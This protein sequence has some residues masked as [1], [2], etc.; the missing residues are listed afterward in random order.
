M[1]STSCFVSATWDPWPPS[2]RPRLATGRE[3]R[4]Q[5]VRRDHLE[6]RVAALARGLVRTPPPE[7]RGVAEAPALH[8]V[9][10][11]LDHQLRPERLPREILALAPAAVAPRHALRTRLRAVLA[12]PVPPGMIGERIRAVGRE[13]RD[14]L[15][16]LRVG[17]ARHHADVL[18]RARR[19][20]E[21]EQERADRHSGT[22]LVPAEARHHAVALPLVLHLEHHPLVRLVGAAFGL[23]HHAVQARALEAS[24]PVGRGAAL[25]GGRRQVQGRLG[26]LEQRLEL[27]AALAERA[28]A[29]V[30]IALAEKVPED[31][32]G[33][34]LLRQHRDA[35]GGGVD[36]QLQRL[37]VESA[38]PRDHDLAVEHAAPRELR[39]ERLAELREVAVERLLV[40][41]LQQELVAVAEDDH[42]ESVPL[43]LED[44]ARAV[45]QLADAPGEHRQHGRA[46]GELHARSLTQ[47]RSRELR[48]STSGPV[49]PSGRVSPLVFLLSPVRCTGQRCR[50]L[51][52]GRADSALALR[53]RR[54][55]APLGEVF[56]FV[57]ALYFRGKLGY[58][59]RF[60]QPPEG[61]PGVLVITPDRGLLAPETAIRTADLRA[62]A[63]VPIDAAEP[64]YARP[65][66]DHARDLAVRLPP[67][68]RIVLLGSIATPK[69]V[70]LLLAA[71]GRA[72]LFP[73]DFVGR[74]DMSR[75]GLLLR[76]E[77]AGVELGYRPVDGAVRRG[78]RAARLPVRARPP[79]ARRADGT[80][81]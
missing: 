72:L 9:V 6:L 69:Y 73:V 35:R 42:P 13:R 56:S 1:S 8:V 65:L 4:R 50:R 17:E 33:R 58:A 48:C 16:P 49:R 63:R 60:A 20:V 27:A 22:A 57:S 81:G 71:F 39:L 18:E 80:S 66:R 5:L 77:R 62:F 59:R 12:R 61:C 67:G 28:G 31:H 15:A 32:R 53:L 74:G 55:G 43:R 21:P 68:A 64:R 11:D 24:E 37:E 45:R 54:E 14:E 34:E 3:D 79:R 25:L 10:R 52:D 7:L 76:A 51:L 47:R 29:Q 19:V 70:D 23:R 75:G 36:A 44:P 78:P 40:A 26:A 38:V 41:A 30:P 2:G 46:D